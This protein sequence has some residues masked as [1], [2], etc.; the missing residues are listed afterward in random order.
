MSKASAGVA[1]TLGLLVAFLLPGIFGH[2]PWKQ[3][4]GY[5][6][7]IVVEILQG[8]HWIVPTLAGEPFM[9]K[10]PLFYLTAAATARLFSGWLPLHDGARLAALLY[11]SIGLLFTGLAGR[12]TFG[13]GHGTL[14][15]LLAAGSVG[16][17]PHAHEMISDTALFAGFAIAI[18]GF[19][20]ALQ[21][22]LLAGA[23]IGTGVGIGFMSK[24][25]VEPAML[26]LAAVALPCVSSQWRQRA[27]AKALGWAALFAL[28]WLVVWPWLLY[29]EN[30]GAF[31]TWF[32]VN[33]F[34]RYFGFAHLG[35]DTEP[36]YYTKALPWFTLPAGPLALWSL[37]RVRDSS[38]EQR[39]ALALFGTI[40]AAMCI[41]LGTAATARALYAIPLLIPLAI[42][43]S[44][45]VVHVPAL[46]G[47][48]ASR[49]AV[50]MGV[51]IAAG[52]SAL[53][54][55]GTINAHAPNIDFIAARLPTSYDFP[56]IAPLV[57]GAAA[58]VAIS[59]AILRHAE[60]TW[61]H[62]WTVGLVLMWG[63]PA[64]LL[65]P[66]IDSARSFREPFKDMSA[67]LQGAD[68][69]IG[70]DIGENQRGMLHYITGVRPFASTLRDDVCDFALWQKN[71][72]SDPLPV[73]LRDWTLVWEGSRPAE[74]DE[75]FYLYHAPLTTHTALSS[76]TVSGP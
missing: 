32:W 67:W 19:T 33:N 75:R 52:A 13:K 26:G 64:T 14:A 34:G 3:D 48:M 70:L 9:E 22:P 11:V 31:Y 53:W 65:L 40:A 45:R 60:S 36:W 50:V 61:V 6:F 63:I 23:V 43:G 49:T 62:R 72:A 68:C 73:G 41:I 56:V 12:R 66:W 17:L 76:T 21:R 69:V 2:D 25:L 16:F 54:L 51:L 55:Y 71:R 24:G 37:W 30:P 57:L 35:A 10:P 5:T 74:R 7:G 20:L 29:R 58:V 39:R 42:L 1:L 44:E 46:V 15:A 28:P 4:E 47:R 27:Y 38:S 8:G 18:Y 59:V